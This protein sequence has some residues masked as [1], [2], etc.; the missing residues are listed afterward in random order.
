[1]FA[2]S[3]KGLEIDVTNGSYVIKGL[4]SVVTNGMN[5]LSIRASLTFFVL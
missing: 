3:I 4:K 1:M 2:Y 5:R